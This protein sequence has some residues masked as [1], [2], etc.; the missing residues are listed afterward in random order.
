M[1]SNTDSYLIKIQLQVQ[2]D[3]ALTLLTQNLEKTAKAAPRAA[4]AMKTATAGTK[5]FGQVAQNT[6][7]QV[8]DLVVQIQ[9]GVDPMRAMSQQ[10]PQMLIGFGAWGAA[11][12]VVAALLP[13]LIT[14]MKA[15]N[16]EIEDT[17]EVAAAAAAQVN[18]LADAFDKMEDAVGNLNL[19]NFIDKF[20]QASKAQEQL[21]LS[22]L[23]F[24]RAI[25]ELSVDEAL[26]KLALPLDV[27][28][29]SGSGA[30]AAYEKQMEA[31]AESVGVAADEMIVLEGAFRQALG[32]DTRTADNLGALVVSLQELS[33]AGGTRN[34]QL[35][36][37]IELLRQAQKATADLAAVEGDLLQETETKTTAIETTN[38]AIAAQVTEVDK[39]IAANDYLQ[40]QAEYADEVWKRQQATL[41]ETAESFSLMD[42][43]TDIFLRTFDSAVDGV[44]RGTQSMSDAFE[45]MT[46]SILLQ[47]GKLLA[48]RGIG[49]ALSS[50]GGTGF[51]SQL[52]ASL[53]AEKGAVVSGGN[54][55]TAYAKGG[56]V[57]GPTVFPM[58]NG[59]GLMGEK[60]PEAVMPLT[61][62]SNGNLGVESSGMNVVINN[63]ASGVEVRPRQTEDGLTIDV[64]MSA[65]SQAVRRGGNEVSESF[66]ASYALN[67]GR[68]VYGN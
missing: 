7:Y 58:A 20:Q 67:R 11:I 35:N 24:R 40:Q 2:N 31:F 21:L 37:T 42:E 10:L 64:V 41:Q 27:G 17:D 16:E 15:G 51:F 38:T 23:R 33:V 3:R 29:A 13:T 54:H 14:L 62:M 28:F 68:A 26:S 47:I 60:S 49:T 32:A 5:R 61:R 8:Q 59:M 45:N 57:S 44:A 53:L 34:T 36:A 22:T 63:N 56:V 39:L 55:L 4:K 12:G 19:D 6:G 30:R 9:G 1:A 18:K 48:I 25:A 65:V 52:G 46:K 66:E 50:G 43:S